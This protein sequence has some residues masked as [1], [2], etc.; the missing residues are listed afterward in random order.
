M[1]HAYLGYH[2]IATE[3][4]EAAEAADD[5]GAPGIIRA[6]IMGAQRCWVLPLHGPASGIPLSCLDARGLFEGRIDSQLLGPH[7]TQPTAYRLQ[8]QD[9]HGQLH[10]GYHPWAFEPTLS[11]DDLHWIGEGT[12][13]QAYEKLGSHIRVLHKVQGLSFAVWAPN[14]QRVSVVGDFNHWDG[15][16][17]PMRRLGASGVWELFI[18]GLGSGLRYKYELIGADGALRLKTDPYAVRYEG[19]PHHAAIVWDLGDYTWSDQA[20]MHQRATTDWRQAPLSIYEVHLGSW[21]R[22]PEDG[23]RPLSYTEAAHALRDYVLEMGFTHVEFMPLAEHPFEGSWG[24]QVT[25][26]FAPTHRYGTP[27][28]FMYL[29][30]TLHQAGIGVIV[31]WVPAHFPRDTFAL[32]DY[33][34]T[35]LYNHADPRQGEHPDWGTL[36]FNY[37]RCEVLGFLINSALAWCRRFHIDGLRVDAVASMLYLNYSR[38]ANEWVPNPY[39]GKENLEALHFLRTLNETLHRECPGVI[40]LAEESTSWGGVTRSPQDQGGLGFDFKWNMGWMHDTLAYFQQDPLFRKHHQDKLTFGMLYQY[41]EVFCNAFSHDEVVHGKGAMLQKMGS[42]HLHDKASTLRSLYAYWFAWPGKKT[43]FMGCEWGQLREWAYDQSLD[44]H[45]LTQPAQ[46]VQP[47][48][49]GIQQL[50]K[51]LNA[52]YRQV[53]QL[54]AWDQD[55]RGFAWVDFEDRDQSI[56]SFLRHGPRAQDTHLIVQN[57]T[58]VTRHAYRVGV[59]LEGYWQECIN[60]DATAYGGQGQG[61]LGGACTQAYGFHRRPHSLL[62]TLPG[63]STLIL[64]WTGLPPLPLVPLAAPSPCATCEPT[65]KTCPESTSA[66]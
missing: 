32:A 16:A 35:H 55:P 52:W 45:L 30:D 53:P 48:H 6:W 50:V 59:P 47:L 39:G 2:P 42:W 20:W 17:H 43:L 25:G 28:E 5:Q 23:N 19:A 18:P 24:Y 58:P 3:A 13:L 21:R 57:N 56:I 44:W 54:A 11:P 27:Q 46:G 62:L 4:I 29:V 1:P 12:H 15:R 51:D 31:D 66:L 38:P 8:W 37:G 14:A 40:T 34:G 33:D 7:P 65:L 26:L 63:L 60:T 36:I 41:S 9:Q 49:R 61:N 10:Q 22:V 64:R